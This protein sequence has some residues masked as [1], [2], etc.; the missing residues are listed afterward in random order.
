[1]LTT[2]TSPETLGKPYSPA[3]DRM[4]AAQVAAELSKFCEAQAA[5]T[6]LPTYSEL[7]GNFGVSDRA[8]RWALEE[9]ERQGKISRRRG[10]R[11]SVSDGPSQNG[12]ATEQAPGVTEVVADRNTVVAFIQPDRSFFDYAMQ[13]LYRQAE[14]AELSLVCRMVNA[15]T[16]SVPV[17]ENPLGYIFFGGPMFLPL[18]RECQQRG[19]RVVTIGMPPEDEAALVPNVRGNQEKGGYLAT[20]HLLEL[21]HRRLVFFGQPHR[22]SPRWR[23]HHRAIEEFRRRGHEISD[24]LVPM[25]EFETWLSDHDRARAYFSSPQAPTGI[26][27]WNDH[28]ATRLIGF[29]AYIGIHVPGQV[30][31]VGYDGLPIGEHSHPALTTVNSSVDDMVQS[32]LEILT[33]PSPAPPT[34]TVIIVPQLVQRESSGPP[35]IS[36]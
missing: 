4:D 11:M 35:P 17:G 20:R 32:A 29:L 36:S 19:Q 18:A 8:V 3:K 1:M 14:S 25:A 12:L 27:A 2:E 33:D 15:R 28:E 16:A 26:V 9:L 22:E 21:G 34:H 5:G 24:D 31:V 7:R 23:G 13:M 6:L 10:A 30:S